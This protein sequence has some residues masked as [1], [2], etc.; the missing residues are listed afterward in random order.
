METITGSAQRRGSIMPA[1]VKWDTQHAK[2]YI[3]NVFLLRLCHLIL[4][5]EEGIIATVHE[6]ID[7][8]RK[9]D[10]LLSIYRAG[11]NP[12]HLVA[13]PALVLRQLGCVWCTCTDL[14]VDESCAGPLGGL[15]QHV[16][17]PTLTPR[18]YGRTRGS[19]NSCQWIV[20]TN[21]YCCDVLW[22]EEC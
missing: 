6:E 18:L 12:E 9:S 11:P 8:V 14:G 10:F 22:I 4:Y 1:M 5:D 13:S 20:V 19:G 21:D 3:W 17:L 2:H 15:G 16:V 7:S